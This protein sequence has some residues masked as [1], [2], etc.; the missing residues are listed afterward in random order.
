MVGCAGTPEPGDGGAPDARDAGGRASSADERLR[1]LLDSSET[2]PALGIERGHVSVLA[3][4]FP[5]SGATRTD[6]ARALLSGNLDL[7]LGRSGDG[8]P[9]YELVERSVSRFGE[10]AEVLDRVVFD[11][12]WRG[13]PVHG[14]QVT[15]VLAGDRIRLVVASVPEAPATHVDLRP[16]MDAA[17]AGEV[18]RSHGE[19]DAVTVGEPQL[20]LLDPAQNGP[21]P[22]AGLHLAW[23]IPRSDGR[24]LIDAHDGAVLLVE[25][26]RSDYLRVAVLDGV[27]PTDEPVLASFDGEC[28]PGHDCSGATAETIDYVQRSFDYHLSHHGIASYDGNSARPW[29]VVPDASLTHPNA[30]WDPTNEAGPRFLFSANFLMPD[31]FGHEYMHAVIEYRH[32]VAYQGESGAINE[33]YADL[34][35]VLVD[36]ESPPLTVDIQEGP[37][38]VM[39]DPASLGQPAS[40]DDYRI[41]TADH[42]G[43]HRNSGIPNLAWCD[44]FLRERMAGRSDAEIRADLDRVAWLALLALPAWPTMVQLRVA[45]ISMA[46]WANVDA[47]PCSYVAAWDRVGVGVGIAP[48]DLCPQL[49]VPPPAD[50]DHDGVPDSEDNC[51]EIYNPLQED[52]DGDAY[53]TPCDWD[54]DGDGLAWFDNCPSIYN[55]LQLS[56][57]TTSSLGDACDEDR[58]AVETDEDNCPTVANP[59]QHDR[60]E[61]NIGDACEPDTDAD[62]APDDADSCP[63]VAASPSDT[64]GDGLG[65]AC[66][67]CPS[68]LDVVVG[69]TT[70]IPSLGIPPAPIVHDADG[71]V[72]PDACDG[73]PF[74]AVV[75]GL[76]G[77][78][79]GA[80]T[81]HVQIDG[82]IDTPVFLPLD[83]CGGVC[84]EEVGDDWL[85]S[86]DFGM[87]PPGSSASIF[88]ELGQ[89]VAA[90]DSYG[91][92]R[93]DTRPER[94]RT[95]RLRVLPAPGTGA[96]ALDL[97]VAYGPPPPDRWDQC[98][99][100]I[101]GSSCYTPTGLSGRCVAGSC[102]ATLADAGPPSVCVGY[103]DGSRC[104]VPDG[105]NGRCAHETC[106]PFAMDAGAGPPPHDAGLAAPSW[107]CDPPVPLS[108]G[109]ADATQPD[110]SA[111]G[112]GGAQTVW[113]E[114]GLDVWRVLG[115]ELGAGGLFGAPQTLGGTGAPPVNLRVA[116]SPAG[117]ALVA[118]IATPFGADTSHH[119]FARVRIAGG[120]FDPTTEMTSGP[121]IGEAAVALLGSG[122]GWGVFSQAPT[123]GAST[124]VWR[125]RGRAAA[126]WTAPVRIDGYTGSTTLTRDPVVALS[127]S[128]VG[129]AAWVD[130]SAG[131][132]RAVAIRGATVGAALRIDGAP[133]TV[134][135]VEAAVDATGAG[136]VVWQQ[137]D[138]GSTGWD[139]AAAAFDGTSFGAPTLLVHAGDG[140][141]SQAPAV[142]VDGTGR[143]VVAWRLGGGTTFAP[144]VAYHQPGMGW[145][146]PHPVSGAGR[147]AD[148]RASL[149]ASGR[150]LIVWR[151]A[152]PMGL[153][154]TSAGAAGRAFAIDAAGVGSD[155]LRV[156]M[157][158]DGTALVVYQVSGAVARVCAVRG[159]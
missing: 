141:T 136:F 70:G 37:I 123:V 150:G 20:V 8:S 62:G 35:G 92:S 152:I 137:Y 39:C 15:V 25:G 10:G 157:L 3:G 124:A 47:D 22:S 101:E 143:A 85:F 116:S 73:A 30:V 159:R 138:P 128:G 90:T 64:D 126:V 156:A 153:A 118:W 29:V 65:D 151:D 120:A 149:D 96:T 28:Q 109:T 42:G 34:Y 45:T 61:D 54:P 80:G 99:L 57:G 155:P 133:S 72:T 98:R 23:R 112:V 7:F 144:W 111:D 102:V 63:F 113:R 21:D 146:S 53:G 140:S 95:Y 110:V 55:P 24:W 108:D 79:L 41:T 38:R 125:V 48:A 33:S 44:V 81:S 135:G 94:G 97:D 18:A 86:I 27:D 122:D 46:S 82:P 67:P 127:P 87:L 13:A 1:A 9:A 117:G 115:S 76:A 100:R 103:P 131:A 74:G 104:L 12:A 158:S 142:A 147:A 17:A 59:D 60:D 78:S 43:V 71:D 119:L 154:V 132:V 11:V 114:P 145:T 77:T 89:L 49:S 51:R 31:M 26:M 130:V 106:E 134:T 139:I 83:P 93:L 88:D 14:A 68:S 2:A 50:Q 69:W 4:R 105:R 91:P 66:D 32:P 58:D 19:A 36:D 52:P 6:R 129:L 75:S 84:P 40:Y 56:T 5:T 121:R 148:L 16:G 107:T